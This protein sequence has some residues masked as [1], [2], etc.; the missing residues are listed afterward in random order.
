MSLLINPYNSIGKPPARTNL[1]NNGSFETNAT[2]WTAQGTNTIAKS[3]EQKLFET[4]SL[5]ITYQNTIA[6]M[7]FGIGD[8]VDLQITDALY[9][10]SYFVYIPANW[11]GGQIKIRHGATIGGFAN[12]VATV[13]VY[14]N[15]AL[16]DQWQRIYCVV[17]PDAADVNGR[18]DVIAVSA[19]TVGRFIYIDGVQVE[20]GGYPTPFIKTDG[21]SANR[22]KSKWL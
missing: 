8:G 21:A 22:L 15:M 9:T 13:E 14:A 10:F 3:T 12:S 5:K 1:I 7:V 4:S 17:D 11:D 6:P 20:L 16:T 2:K 19:P 18:I